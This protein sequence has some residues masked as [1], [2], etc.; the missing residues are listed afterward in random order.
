MSIKFSKVKLGELGK[1]SMCKRI[2]KH[3]TSEFE[4]IP[5]YK[6]STFGGM[7]DTFISREIYELYKHKY[8][9]PKVG[10]VLFSAAGTIG[11]T[12]IYDGSPAFFQDSNIVWIAND[13]TIILN[14]FLYY[15]YQTKPWITSKGSTILRLYNDNIRSIEINFPNINIQSQIVKV[16]SDLDAKIELNNKINAELEAM[17]KLIY[18]YWFVQFDFPYKNGKPYKTSGGKMVWNEELKREVPE[19]WEVKEIQKLID[20]KDGTHDSPKSKEIGYPLIT[21]KN[22]KPSGLDYNEANLISK[23]D[24]DSI[25]KRSKVETGD[26]LFSMIGNI[27]TIYKVEEKEIGFTVK[28]VAI[29]KS[30]QKNEFKNFIY[31]FLKS[32]DMDR[33]MKNVISGS[34]QKFIG[35]NSLRNTPV[36]I[37]DKMVKEFNSKTNS[38]FLTLEKNKIENQKLSELRDWLLPMLMN[39]Q[40][41]IDKFSEPKEHL[42]IA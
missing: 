2:L 38:I 6:I 14:R 19:G 7:A 37:N 20:V 29:F 28:N 39:G 13:E 3:E 1:V 32:I 26:I 42:N 33:Y 23:E 35:L 25:N 31:M 24:Y 4:E 16:L 27:G 11:K 12:V 41:R 40:V 15:F 30:S 21:S 5:F 22:L 9:Y 17:A 34:I 36:F 18:D 10:D 8:S